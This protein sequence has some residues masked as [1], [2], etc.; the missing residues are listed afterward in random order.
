[1]ASELAVVE[2]QAAPPGRSACVPGGARE[3]REKE[4]EKRREKGNGGRENNLILTIF[5]HP[6]NRELI[7]SF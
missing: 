2:L 4:G 1:V 5:S 7:K 3:E 6:I